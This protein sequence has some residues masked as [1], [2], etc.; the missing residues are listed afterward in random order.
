MEG[1]MPMKSLDKNLKGVAGV[2][3]VVAHLSL[4]GFVALATT[5]NIKSYDIVAFRP[6]LSKTVFLQVKSTDRPKDGWHVYTIP[7]DATEKDWQGRLKKAVSLG[8]KFF[9]IFVELSKEKK[10]EPSFYVVPSL[11]VANILIKRAKKYFKSHENLKPAG[12]F[13]AWGHRKYDPKTIKKYQNNWELLK[14]K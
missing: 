3:F 1:K 4:E 13:L 7:K 14:H 11:D 9:Y 12:Q 6:D 10:A 8:N 2:H 5:R